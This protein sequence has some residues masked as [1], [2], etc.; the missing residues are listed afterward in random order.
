MIYHLKEAF[1]AKCREVGE[2]VSQIEDPDL[3]RRILIAI[4]ELMVDPGGQWYDVMWTG[5]EVPDSLEG[6]DG[7]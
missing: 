6:F 7:A 2:L 4:E 1:E 3:R 5:T